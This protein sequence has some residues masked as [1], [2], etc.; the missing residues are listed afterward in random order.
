MPIKRTKYELIIKL[1]ISLKIIREINLLNLFRSISSDIR[2]MFNIA[3]A[4]QRA[5]NPGQAKASMFVINGVSTLTVNF[6]SG[7]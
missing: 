6:S 4:L 7:G 5:S 2:M 1:I 3:T